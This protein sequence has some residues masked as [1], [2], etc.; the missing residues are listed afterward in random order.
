MLASKRAA[1]K[2]VASKRVRQRAIALERA[3][4]R[5]GALEQWT[6][7][8]AAA[9]AAEKT[10]P[11]RWLPSALRLLA[12]RLAAARGAIISVTD[13]MVWASAGAGLAPDHPLAAARLF[14]GELPALPELAAAPRAECEAALVRLLQQD[15]SPALLG[16]A[17]QALLAA[18]LPGA[19]AARRSARGARLGAA[20]KQSGSYY[21]PSAAS[22]ELVERALER[23]PEPRWVCDPAVGG[24]AFL[25]ACYD[26]LVGERAPREARLAALARLV[27]ADTSQ[28]ALGLT[29]LSLWLALG[30]PERPIS[31]LPTR[32]IHGDSLG[33][34]LG[35]RVSWAREVPDVFQQGGFQLVIGNPPWVAFAGRAAQPLAKQVRGA[36]SRR[37]QAWRGFPTLQSAFV[38]LAARTLAPR[39]VISL[40]LPSPIAD[41]SGYA[42]LRRV[43]TERHALVTPLRE[44][45]RRAFTEVAQ[46][47]F[48]LLLSPSEAATAS[49]EPWPLLERSGS[50]ALIE[51]PDVLM[52][53]AD[54]PRLPRSC[55]LER[56]FR[57]AGD[58][59][60]RLLRRA[61]APEGP[62]QVPLL[63]GKC[64][65]AFHR[66][67]P[68]L[69]FH[70]D[71]AVLAERHVRLRSAAHFRA[72]HFIVRQTA[73]R[74]IAAL[75]DGGAFRNSLIAGFA[76]PPYSA[77]TLVA[78]LNSSLYHALHLALFR[79]AR[80]AVFPQVK[81]GHLRALPAPPPGPALNLV[82]ALG[83][84]AI[85]ARNQG[86][87]LPAPLLAAL[88]S[89][90]YA[91]FGI[92]QAD[93]EA[94]EG[95]LAQHGGP[96]RRARGARW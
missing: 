69:F 24:G 12:L 22:R 41:L 92:S 81:V 79:D 34:G 35:R 96:R 52:R 36:L 59:G 76:R 18:R 14:Q 46:P 13:D 48:G 72:V 67:P 5:A 31:E 68:R 47:C 85:A 30:L 77:V 63:E 17:Y 28:L 54:L 94:I 55:F 25:L 27:G 10:P 95:F 71:E 19:T 32:L 1:T 49:E 53:L 57:T 42:A 90:V 29:E 7:R 86:Q 40:L 75:H 64:V 11:A 39:G 6:L 44:V 89:A 16:R 21:T 70:P 45:S 2:R 58:V 65:S 74:P 61:A 38:E 62:F 23:C 87:P 9:Y 37:Y 4:R 8:L 51:P 56:G 91:A 82:E 15:T 66:G 80:Q 93:R 83:A 43:A 33:V 20:R 3:V 88:E 78:L 50:A 26:A 73:Y 60:R 84:A